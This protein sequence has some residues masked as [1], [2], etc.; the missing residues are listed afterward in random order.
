MLAVCPYALCAAQLSVARLTEYLRETGKTSAAIRRRTMSFD[1][2]APR[3]RRKRETILRR[4]GYLCRYC[5][6]YGRRRQAT[7]VHHIEHADEHPEL[8]Y[9]ADNLISLCE[10]CHNK[11]HPEKAKNAGR[12][13]I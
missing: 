2:N 3:W 4:D 12:Y 11:M 5:L 7:T 6:R 8:A 1:Y 9:N 10:A 13:G